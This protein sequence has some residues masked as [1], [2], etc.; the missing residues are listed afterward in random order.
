ME[1]ITLFDLNEHLRRVLA[2][3]YPEALWVSCEIAQMNESRGHRFFNLVEKASDRDALIAQAEGVL[4]ERTYLRLRRRIGRSLD[5]LLR[6][7]LEVLLNVRVDFHERYGIKLVIE[8]VDPAYTLGRLEQLRRE[9]IEQLRRQQLLHCNS[10]L[11]LPP[12][13][14]RIAVLSSEGSAGYQDYRRQLENNPYG[15][16]FR[17]RHFPVAVQ[18][19]QVE[20]EVSKQLRRIA[21]HPGEFD[22]VVLIRG[23][24]AR[25]DLAA[26]DS[27]AL[28]K[29][30]AR[31]PLPVITGIGHDSDETVVDIVAHTAL[32]TPTAVADF[33]VDRNLRF[34]TAI[35][36]L[37]NRLHLGGRRLIEQEALQLAQA[38]QL[39]RLQCRNRIK[40]QNGL[41]NTI[42]KELPALT[43]RALRDH[44]QR[45]DQLERLVA[46][47]H[48]EATLKR[49]YTLT[50]KDGRPVTSAT[51]LQ[52]GDRIVTR[53]SDGDKNSEISKDE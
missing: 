20:K 45:L 18:G 51:G 50:L 31:H 15:F 12:V 44:H 28:G 33:L 30:I 41:L 17:N 4:W 19:V 9:V 52:P 14:Q 3:N 34:E 47:L 42:E 35:A 7:G 10:E 24:G 38:E 13:L 6:E 16:A 49:G 1:S 27:L 48:P 2:L 26:F 25:I 5:S 43:G 21:H 37:G 39:I 46:L 53:F 8:D 11:P 29:A 23:G 22:C 36:E 40:E 32:K